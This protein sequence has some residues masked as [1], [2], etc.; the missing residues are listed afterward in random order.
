MDGARLATVTENDSSACAVPSLTRTTTLSKVPSL[1]TVGRQE[2][3]R[4]FPVEGVSWQNAGLLS[5][6]HVSGSLS[7]SEAT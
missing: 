5:V 6:V 4:V 3:V 2:N 1:A 7:G